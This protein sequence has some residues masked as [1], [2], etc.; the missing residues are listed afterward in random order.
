M[1]RIEAPAGATAAGNSYS[2]EPVVTA[3]V[4]D[5]TG[6]GQKPLQATHCAARDEPVNRRP[7]QT[8]GLLTV[9]PSADCRFALSKLTNQGVKP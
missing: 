8:C 3:P 4:V 9:S 2:P 1:A 6:L 5:S 7:A